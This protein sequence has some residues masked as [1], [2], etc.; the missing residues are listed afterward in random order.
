MLSPP[1][2]TLRPQASSR[3]AFQETLGP[4]SLRPCLCFLQA[5]DSSHILQAY[6]PHPQ[7]RA[8]LTYA[9]S[10]L[11]EGQCPMPGVQVH[12]NDGALA[13]PRGEACLVALVVEE[14]WRTAGWG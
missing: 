7:V 11:K 2:E 9:L 13:K 3:T 10:V 1:L 6:V 4:L 5:L 8:T 12:T 14:P